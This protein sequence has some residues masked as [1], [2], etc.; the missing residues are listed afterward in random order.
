MGR[1]FSVVTMGFYMSLAYACA[2][3]FQPVV[4]YIS[5]WLL[6]KGWSVSRAR[7]S[8]QVTLQVLS[9]TIIFSGYADNVGIAM[10]FLVL[11]ISAE[12][13]CAGHMWTIISEVVPPKLVG[14]VGGL[15]NMVGSAAG[16]VSPIVTGVVVKVTG[17][18]KL[19]LLLGGSS[20]LLAAVV[21]LFV[22]PELKPLSL[23][24]EKVKTGA[25]LVS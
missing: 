2:A 25:S 13:T 22:V 18:F 9:A 5:D 11:A 19:A 16:I 14:S 7:K 20:I 3:V 23:E 12:S 6:K 8:V 21:L 1:G 4:G 24:S 10:F 17:S 15:I